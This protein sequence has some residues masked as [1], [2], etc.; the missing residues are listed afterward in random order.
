VTI[1]LADPR[2][3][4]LGHRHEIDEALRRVLEGGRYIL[5]PEVEAFEAEFAAYVGRDEGVGVG[6]GTEAL[7]LGLLACGVGSGD[8]VATVSH[9]ATATAAAIGLAGATP[10][11]V[12]V[13]PATFTMDPAAL[14]AA[15]TGDAG[16]RIRAVVPVHLYGHPAA[17]GPIMEIARR[18][19]LRV[20][21]DCAQAHGA[22]L[23]G[24]RCGGWG[25]LAAF[26]FYPTKNLGALGDGG[27]LV[28]DR[29]PASQ[30]RRLREYGWRERF[31]SDVPGMNTR[32]D[33]L[34][35][36]VLRV[37]LAYLDAEN[38]HRREL[39]AL[40]RR[41]LPSSVTLPATAPGA[42]HVF[43]QFVVRS[44]A[45]DALRRRL[46][47][48]GVQTGIHYPLPVHRQPAYA[49]SPTGPGGLGQTD[50]LCG[51]ILSLPMHPYLPGSDVEEICRLVTTWSGGA[52]RA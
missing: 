1:L 26:S 16:R 41:G 4:Y 50:R 35:A 10:L 31:V 47:E 22:Q 39:A 32:L 5:G 28:G 48:E 21:E 15:V 2:A 34:Q 12:D 8:F 25:D 51:E 6:S 42:E 40:Y 52:G 14:E 27:A 13:D 37:K 43:H 20:V 24:V 36:A 46:A 11:F 3:A 30:A 38:A 9:T 33:E 19:G 44:G 18:Y 17:M 45:R 7:H 29:G 49:G 23:G